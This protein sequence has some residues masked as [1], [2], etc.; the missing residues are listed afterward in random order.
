M[1][2]WFLF[3]FL[4]GCTIYQSPDRKAFESESPSF[5][6]ESLSQLHCSQTSIK[7][8]ATASRLVTV[9]NDD[10][11]ESIFLWEYIINNQSY[12]ESDNL[13]GNFCVYQKN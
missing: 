3:V 1:K 8:Q 12:F 2:P 11:N 7:P 13:K 5:R 4:A 10:H 9:N 6:I